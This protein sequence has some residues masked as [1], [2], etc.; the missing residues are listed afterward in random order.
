MKQ[1]FFKSAILLLLAIALL[2]LPGCELLDAF[3]YEDSPMLTDSSGLQLHFLDVG[4]AD[5]TLIL[6]DS[7][8]MLIDG[9][10]AADSSFI[11]A[12]LE[13][14]GIDYLDYIICTHAHEDHVGGLAGALNYAEAG[15][16]FC[17]VDDYDSKAFKSFIK[18]V[19]QQG[20]ELR[21]PVVGERFI[22]GAAQFEIL[23]PVEDYEDTNNTS[24][25]IKLTYG[26]HSF[27]F[28]GDAEREAETA[29]LEAGT[30]V[31][32]TLLH[33][34]HHGSYTST[35]YRFLYEANPKYAIISCGEG[36][37]YG[38]PHEE[39]TSRLADADVEV[40][41]TDLSGTIICKSDGKELMFSFEK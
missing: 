4:Q 22:F 28:T 2:I 37:S 38:H 27:L 15:T 25:S 21:K 32:C 6:C 9:G 18:Y 11:Y 36:N 8:V 26:E 30:D 31:S 16:V 23:G 29:M 12:Y 24:I 39:V 3:L 1:R 35:S 5:A 41:R 20:L 10:N 17:P 7:E 14:Y 34:G 13:K 33:I 19:E 40:F